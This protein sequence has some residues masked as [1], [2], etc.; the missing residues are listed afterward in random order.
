VRL[1]RYL[2]IPQRCG[3]VR[4]IALQRRFFRDPI[5]TLT[6]EQFVSRSAANSLEWRDAGNGMLMT[7]VDRF[8]VT[9]IETRLQLS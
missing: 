1:Y 3:G 9:V 4:V 8:G 6:V 5:E 7:A 2:A